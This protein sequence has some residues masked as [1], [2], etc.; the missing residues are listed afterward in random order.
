[1]N[2]E[3][4][5]SNRAKK[6]LKNTDKDL[7]D[8]IVKRLEELSKD[9]FPMDSKRVIGQKEKVFRV[10]V[11]DYRIL[12]AVFLEENSLLVVNIDKRSKVYRK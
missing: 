6:F 5:L 12:Y 8:R 1:L 10:R 9:P 4:H 2:F 11:G 7:F 3:I